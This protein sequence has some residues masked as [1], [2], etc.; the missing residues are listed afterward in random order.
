MGTLENLEVSSDYGIQFISE[1]KGRGLFAKKAYKKGDL[2]F[3]ESPLVCAQFSWNVAYGY[4]AC[5][6][7]MRPLETAEENAQEIIWRLCTRTTDF[8]NVLPLIR[9]VK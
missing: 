9:V 6:N 1:L 5:E 4:L 3:E 2:I 8:L 7:C